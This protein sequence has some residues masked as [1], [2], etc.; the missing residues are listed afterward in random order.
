MRWSIVILVVVLLMPGTGAPAQDLET[1]LDETDTGQSMVTIPGTRPAPVGSGPAGLEGL[2]PGPGGDLSDLLARLRKFW[3][4]LFG[5]G[6]DAISIPDIPGLTTPGPE[7]A[8]G[9]PG[10]PGTGTGSGTSTGTG[11]GSG[12]GTGTGPGTVAPATEAEYAARA[13]AVIDALKAK[14]TRPG[15]G[16]GDAVAQSQLGGLPPWFGELQDLLCGSNG[17]TDTEEEGRGILRDYATQWAAANLPQ[18]TH[19]TLPEFFKYLGCAENNDSAI[20]SYGFKKGQP[21]IP[22]SGLMGGSKGGNNWC[23][24]ASNKAYVD[25]IKAAGFRVSGEYAWA[26]NTSYIKQYGSGHKDFSVESGDYISNGTHAM[27]VVQVRGDRV[28]AVSGNAGG[29]SVAYSGTVRLHEISLASIQIVKKH[30]P[31][32]LAV[33]QAHA[34][35]AAWL[36]AHGLSKR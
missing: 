15:V 10:L 7:V 27:T 9:T 1:F 30:A 33:I 17:W 14:G 29:G 21:N 32:S 13:Q 8:S 12:T 6:P 16:A 25:P 3:A 26:N 20:A 11:T 23:A 4:D 19:H 36:R 22:R 31:L 18:P 24:F 34:D 5:A 2:T 35:D 28:L